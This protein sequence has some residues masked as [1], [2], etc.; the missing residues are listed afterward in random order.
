MPY[1]QLFNNYYLKCNRTF[2]LEGV[3][4]NLSQKTKLF[5]DLIQKNNNAAD[6]I[7]QIAA[8][9]FIESTNDI[10]Q[11]IFVINKKNI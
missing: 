10:K 2:V 7:K 4:V 1:L 6:K 5:V 11:P 8:H 3:K 9:N